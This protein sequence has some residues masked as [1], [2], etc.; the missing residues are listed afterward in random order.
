MSKPLN[1]ILLSIS[2]VFVLIIGK[3]LIVPLVWAVLVWYLI[4]GVKKAV[5]NI[6]VVGKMLPNWIKV[7][8]SVTTFLLIY[9]VLI[10]LVV[11]NLNKLTANF[12]EYKE[13]LTFIS[14]YIKSLGITG[15]E[16]IAN[17]GMI[18]DEALKNLEGASKSL[19]SL[20]SSLFLVIVFVVFIFLDE[21]N[22]TKKLKLAF[23]GN[24]RKLIIDE[25][26]KEIDSA[27]ARYLEL[28]TLMS[29]LTAVLSFSVLV[30]IGVEAPVFWAL[31]I[32]IL[33]YIPSIGSL[34]ATLFPT[35][36]AFLQYGDWLHP[37]IVMIFVGT[38][39]IIVGNLVEPRIMGKSLNISS[40]VVMISL[41]FWTMIWGVSGAILSVP[42]M[43]ILMILF[44]HFS[45][46]K[47]IAILL[48]EN[49]E[50]D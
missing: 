5:G 34:I 1:I 39:Q 11:I 16:D 36:M 28:K 50:I 4:R 15:F 25:I 40:L 21:V 9:F 2:I 20:L 45:Q 49:G 38:I 24:G 6:P 12:S 3:S 44:K 33:N 27:I 14:D 43:V 48:S 46:T 7:I 10:D 8:L 13:N 30:I 19:S 42:I 22:M 35:V 32:F 17:S 37:T 23:V 18:E 41:T 47:S 29:L 31:I 26:L